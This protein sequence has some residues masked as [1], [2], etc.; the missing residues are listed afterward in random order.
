MDRVAALADLYVSASAVEPDPPARAGYLTRVRELLGPPRP[1][2]PRGSKL[3][4]LLDLA[5]RG[6]SGKL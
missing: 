2:F 5:E 4:R 6:L 3:A 1:S